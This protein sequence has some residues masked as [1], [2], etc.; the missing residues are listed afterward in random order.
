MDN[1]HH[2]DHHHHHHSHQHC[3]VNSIF[4]IRKLANNQLE[5]YNGLNVFHHLM[6]I[7]KFIN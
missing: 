6:Q 1:N 2:H 4:E 5:I 7:S 3:F